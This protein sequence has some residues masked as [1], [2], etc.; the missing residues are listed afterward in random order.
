MESETFYF[1]GIR[2]WNSLPDQIKCINNKISFKSAVKKHLLTEM[3]NTA[4][5]DFLYY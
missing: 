1:N 2:D 3:K 5:S 4:D